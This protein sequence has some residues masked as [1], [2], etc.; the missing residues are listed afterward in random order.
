MFFGLS[1]LTAAGIYNATATPDFV[2]WRKHSSDSNFVAYLGDG[3]GAGNEV[4]SGV[5]PPASTPVVFEIRRSLDYNPTRMYLNDVLVATFPSSDTQ[6]VA[7][8]TM[9]NMFLTFYNASAGSRVVRFYGMAMSTAQ[10]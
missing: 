9:W 7:G 2:G 5:S 1:Q 10:I 6:P 8:T 4:D 3:V